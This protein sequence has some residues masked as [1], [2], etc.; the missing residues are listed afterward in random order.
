MYEDHVDTCHNYMWVYKWYM[1]PK[2]VYVSLPFQ[3]STYT[4]IFTLPVGVDYIV[5]GK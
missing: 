4:T 1:P 2:V 5:I 3:L